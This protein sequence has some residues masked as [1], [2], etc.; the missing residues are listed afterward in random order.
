MTTY[1]AIANETIEFFDREAKKYLNRTELK[2]RMDEGKPVNRRVY[3]TQINDASKNDV[4]ANMKV[5]VEAEALKRK[6]R[7][8]GTNVDDGYDIEGDET[9]TSISTTRFVKIEEVTD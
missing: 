9:S 6:M 4:L 7:T 1:Y 3:F 8:T 5:I 2:A